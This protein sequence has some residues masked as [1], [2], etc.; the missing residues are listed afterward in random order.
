[1]SFL[2]QAI[3]DP[4]CVATAAPPLGV[5]LYQQWTYGFL[6]VLLT[7]RFGISNFGWA[8]V[9]FL[10]GNIGW[11]NADGPLAR[12]DFIV[13][14]VVYFLIGSLTGAA[15]STIGDY[16]RLLN[17]DILRTRDERRASPLDK[18]A[19]SPEPLWLWATVIFGFL[20][21]SFF[22]HRWSKN[23]L[24]V[25]PSVEVWLGV[26]FLVLTIVILGVLI[27]QAFFTP[28]PDDAK[29]GYLCAKYGYVFENR[30]R[31]KYMVVL[32][33]LSSVPHAIIDFS[34]L[35]GFTVYYG[36]VA[37]VALALT[38]LAVYWYL[39]RFCA[40]TWQPIHS[41]A[42]HYDGMGTRSR[43]VYF[44][45][46]TGLVHCI[47][48]GMIYFAELISGHSL[49]FGVM[50]AVVA[51]AKAIIAALRGEAILRQGRPIQHRK[52]QRVRQRG[53]HSAKEPMLASIV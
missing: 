2:S 42:H 1:M 35:G 9:S 8:V 38:Y 10:I 23:C 53:R 18:R 29:H 7:K 51:S 33:V 24:K 4:G 44:V 40:C 14:T 26:L 5:L 41:R 27:Y 49:L 48:I 20:S 17:L 11:H 32:V 16:P 39:S 3:V 12:F 21:A 36:L 50:A 30:R 13:F 37:V 46:A 31:L 52:R 45:V 22:A 19:F 25:L 43:L 6:T 34:F 28:I 47:V 15:L